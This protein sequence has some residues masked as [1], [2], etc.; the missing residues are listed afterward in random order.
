MQHL[1][2]TNT[3]I[4]VTHFPREEIKRKLLNTIIN[5]KAQVH[6]YDSKLY[7][8]LTKEPDNSQIPQFYGIPKIHKQFIKVPPVRPIVSQCNSVLKPIA[9]FIDHILQPLARSYPDFLYN[10]T[11]LSQTLQNLHVPDDA[12]LTTSDVKSLYP[13][14]P[15]TEML[16]V[17]YDEMQANRHLLLFDPNLIIQLLHTCINSNFFEF[18]SMTFQQING[19]AMGAAFSPTV[20]NIYM[21]VTIRKFLQTQPKHPLL[22]VRYID[23]IFVI[24]S[25]TKEELSTFL[26]NMNSFNPALEYTHQCSSSTVD[27]L[28]LTIYKGPLFPFTNVLDTRTYQKIHNLYQYLHYSSNNNKATYKGIIAGELVRYV[29]T[30]TQKD[31]YIAMTKLLK[32]RLLVRDYPTS[33]IDKVITTVSFEARPHLLNASKPP[34]P[35]FYPPIFKC[36]LPPQFKLLKHIILENYSCLQNV[37]PAPRFLALRHRALKN[38]LV[39]AKLTPTEDQLT[40]IKT[41]VHIHISAHTSAGLLPR[42]R[43]PSIRTQRCKHRRCVTCKHL[44][45]SRFIRST[46]TGRSYIIR[47]SF[48]C[49]SSYLI[50]V[51]TCTKCRKQYVG[52]TNRQLNVRINHHR[53]NIF[54]QKPIYISKHFNLPDHS[55]N[56]L[57]VQ[58]IDRVERSNP[59][60]LQELQKLESYWINNLQTLQP[61]GL[62]VSAGSHTR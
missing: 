38:D 30:N 2:D 50:Y 49:T 40:E 54:N 18:A 12:I 61:S 57:S 47:H 3:Y 31:N 59:N 27:F 15:R 13:S 45:C 39:R 25:H 9:Q 41:L 51:I 21:S 60:P 6:G 5:F 7:D 35:R 33:L 28:E 53:T 56:N 55:I 23:D 14:I 37:V 32:T 22:L 10:S 4:S 19:T 24:W 20:A 62:N 29:R 48:S 52:L 17:I 1:S 44:N 58:A 34:P 26:N 43:E 42:L 8:F 16:Q 46:K 36:L 11:A